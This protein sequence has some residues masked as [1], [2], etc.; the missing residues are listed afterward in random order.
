MVLVLD[1]N[2]VQN[3]PD[4]GMSKDVII[5]GV[6]ISLFVHIDNK[7]RYLNSWNRSNITI[8]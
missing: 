2:H 6:Y 8:R 3:L 1:L 7:K 4:G 5:F